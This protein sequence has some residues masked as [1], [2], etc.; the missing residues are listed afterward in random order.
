MGGARVIVGAGAHKDP[1]QGGFPEVIDTYLEHGIMK[2]IAFNRRGTLLAAGCSD[3]RC[4]VWDF[5]TRGIAKELK[6][7]DCV[8]SI[9]SVCWS[10]SGHHILVSA[11]DSSLTLWNVSKGE[12]VTQT[13]LQQTPLQA[14]LHPGSNGQSSPPSLCLVSPSSSAPF[15]LDLHTQITTVLPISSSDNGTQ[16][17]F[18]DGS[19]NYTPTAA[20]FNKSGDLVYLG[21]S[22]G[23]ILIIDH[24]SNK[25]CGIVQIPGGAVIKNIVFSRNGQHLLTNSSDRIIRVYESLLPLKC[26]L[27]SFEENEISEIEKLK[28]VGLKSLS[29]FREFQ[30]SITKVHWK[31]PCFS[32]DSVWIVG[33]SASKGEHKIYIWDRDGLLVKLLEGPKE[34]LVDLAWH[35]IQP[36]V[37]SVSLTGLVYIW[38][39][40]YT[41][42][43][44]VFAPDFKEL[45]ENEEYVEQEDEFDLNHD[46]EKVKGSCLNEDDEI[47]IITVEKDTTFSESD[48]SQEELCYL[49]AHPFPDVSEKL[50]Q[51]NNCESP[52][53]NDSSETEV[54]ENSVV[55][56]TGGAHNAVVE[57]SVVEYT[58]GTHD[59]V[60][61][62]MIEYTGG[63]DDAVVENSLVEYTGDAVVENSVVEYTGGAPLKRKRKR[64]K[65]L[66]E[67][68]DLKD[69]NKT[70]ASDCSYK[71]IFSI[72]DK[73]LS[74]TEFENTKSPSKGHF[75]SM[76]WNHFKNFKKPNKKI[77]A[78][79]NYC[80]VNFVA[81]DD[82]INVGTS[83]LMRHLRRKHAEL[84]APEECSYIDSVSSTDDES[85]TEFKEVRPGIERKIRSKVW[86]YYK[87]LQISNNE[88]IADCNFCHRK[89]VSGRAGT[90]H[91]WNHIKRKH[92]KEAGLVVSTMD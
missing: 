34:A 72:P 39:K 79:C 52:L 77:V 12:K 74:I 30:D 78:V 55:L 40:D 92:T 32:G 10:K 35:P 41:E 36:I 48:I 63:T 67:L 64:S 44:S 70:I 88:S 37:V 19:A 68:Q 17:N 14:C 25:V 49:P 87:R 57:N 85:I 60:V 81:G 7:N 47:D 89:F 33:G 13:V 2:C 69:A 84:I 51:S 50:L 59:A 27:K 53:S 16:N 58:G 46:I 65:K 62:S 22:I 76:V 71:E 15:I 42:N 29:L 82:R 45:E 18:S 56:Y 86:N 38:V 43:W 90:H 4:V 8:A 31:A 73:D 91:L 9:T 5:Q 75:R 80:S 61:N 3:G 28:S 23:E 6:N 54:V 26:S 11:A 21:N 1:L 20:C 24:K 66:L 83:N